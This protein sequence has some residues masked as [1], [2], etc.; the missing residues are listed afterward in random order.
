MNLLKSIAGALL[1]LG[2]LGGGAQGDDLR[3]V[4]RGE[5]VPAFRMSAS[6]GTMIDSSLLRGKVVVLVYL[7]AE[8]K[9]SEQAAGDSSEVMKKFGEA[10]VTLLHATAD[11]VHKPYF[12]RLR[13]ER[14][15][16]AP[17][18]LDTGRR[19]YGDLGLIVFP[20]TIVADKEG[21]LRHV[22][23]TRSPDYPWILECSIRHALGEFDDA[24]LAERLKSR[25]PELGSPK[26]LAARH[27]SAARLLREKGLNDAARAELL[28]AREFDPEDPNITLDLADIDLATGHADEARTLAAGIL[29]HNP[30]HRRAQEIAGVAMFKLGDMEAARTILTE[31]IVLNPSPARALYFLGRIDEA[32]GRGAEAMKRYRE[33]LE[34]VLGE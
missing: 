33:A 28:R 1:I 16:E 22:I 20:T 26:S 9:S 8:Q 32:Q 6:D 30:V 25:G 14:G 27:R 34:R 10:P 4:K 11:I 15:I 31:S 21:V 7:S 24:T 19:L 12:D 2:V 13:A 18:G 3:N 17:L 29:E 5:A 23:S